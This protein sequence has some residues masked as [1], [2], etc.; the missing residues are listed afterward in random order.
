MRSLLAS[1]SFWA[2]VPVGIYA[3]ASRLRFWVLGGGTSRGC[4]HAAPGSGHKLAVGGLLG[5]H[6][7]LVAQSLL[8]ERF[9][10]ALY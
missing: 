5:E 3:V 1:Q 9:C 2:D 6:S 7:G 4:V 8:C 10:E